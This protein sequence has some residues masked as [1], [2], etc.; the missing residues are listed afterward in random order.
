MKSRESGWFFFSFVTE[1]FLKF[2]SFFFVL[3]GNVTALAQDAIPR[4]SVAQSYDVLSS[5]ANIS[6]YKAVL[7]AANYFGRFFTGQI[8]AAGKVPPAKVFVIGAGVAGLAAIGTAR[9]MGAVVRAFDT[10]PP[11]K[12][13][14]ESM[15]AQFLEIKGVELKEGTGGYAAEQG[16]EVQR[17]QAELTMKHAAEVDIIVTT[18][19]I[20]GRPAP[21][22]ITKE[23]V[24]AMTP[25]S[26]IVD[27]AAEAGGNCELTKPGEVTVQRARESEKQTRNHETHHF[28]F[29]LGLC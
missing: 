1:I 13:Q 12:E 29:Y 11:V 26:V 28:L 10:R 4:T 6:G 21:R 15:G 24:A 9:A 23:M 3:L 7:L 14:V 16:A 17:K 18:A 5:M 20:P 22:L 25:G 19:L 8:T 2:H 27:L